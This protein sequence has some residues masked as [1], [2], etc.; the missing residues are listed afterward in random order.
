MI[1]SPLRSLE[2][3]AGRAIRVRDIAQPLWAM[4]AGRTAE[5][6]GWRRRI[7][8]EFKT[9]MIEYVRDSAGGLRKVAAG[10]SH[11]AAHG[12]AVGARAFA[13]DPFPQPTK[14]FLGIEPR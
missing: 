11:H 13:L 4:R 5:R 6:L 14:Q 1:T 12:I 10:E 3:L 8:D 7:P 9:Q 2:E